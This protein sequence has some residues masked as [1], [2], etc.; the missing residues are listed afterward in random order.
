MNE[1]TQKIIPPIREINTSVQ[2]RDS[3]RKED[4]VET[5][6]G[7]VCEINM[8]QSPPSS[9]YN[10]EGIG[11][12]FF[13]G[14]AEFTELHPIVRKWC[15]VPK[16]I[17]N[18]WDILLSVRAPVGS[19]N[20]ANQ[21][22]AIGRG[23]AAITYKYDNMFIW[24]YLKS[25]E[26]KLDNQGTGTTFKAI[27]GAILKSQ[28]IELPP[29]IEQRAIVR[30]IEEL[31]S[32]LD[33]GIA[34]LKKAQ[35]QLKIYR[36]AVLKKAF[37]D[38]EKIPF[39]QLITSA[40]NGMSK[41]KGTEGKEIKV[42]RLAD[43]TKL[44]IDNSTPRTILL[45]DKELDKYKLSEG[46]LL[47]IRVNGSIDLVGK[48]V[49]VTNKDESEVWA[50]CDHLIRVKLNEIISLPKFYYYYLQIPEVRKYIHE[51]MVSSAGQNTVSQSTVK[52]ISAPITTIDKQHQIVQEIESRL[53]VCDKVEKDLAESLDKAE[54]LRQSI[55]KK[56]FEG[57][58]LTEEEIAQCKADPDYEPASVLLERIK[59]EK[60]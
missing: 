50:F 11:L 32:S 13:Q 56:A 2:I 18:K 35:E 43:I 8:G 28:K 55:L 9:T 39:E 57:K 17:A 60:K 45:N 12:P 36:Q 27:S 44:A 23:L 5:K 48:F 26:R 3:D 58:L 29:L 30:K 41:R 42:L 49:Y 54:A 10:T 33:S 19:T 16:K 51:N 40:Q 24:F 52:S 1:S 31:F 4:W 38:L 25:I 34:D 37:E 53:S 47:A 46:D 20:I 15:S 21:K 7:E 59:A 22:C 14:K 6:L